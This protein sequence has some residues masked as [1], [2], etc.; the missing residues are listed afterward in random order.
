VNEL[1]FANGT[2]IAN[3]EVFQEIYTGR[4][5]DRLVQLGRVQNNFRTGAGNDIINA[6]L[7]ISDR[8]D[9]GNGEDLLI[10]NYSVEDTGT[11]VTASGSS[12]YRSISSSNSNYLDYVSFSSIERFQ[13]TG[14]SKNDSFFTNSSVNGADT[15]IGGGG[16]DTLTSY[17]GNDS[18]DGGSGNDRLTGGSGRDRFVLAQ[19][20]GTDTI[21]DFED[22]QDT[23]L[24][25]GGL[26]FGQLTITQSSNNALIG[27]AG[28]NE[29]LASLTGVQ[30]NLITEAD[31]TIV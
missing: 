28:S 22:G 10:L 11:G 8:V 12:A 31:F 16:D 2:R 29:V 19:G 15:L 13:F 9:G 24:L 26:T 20:Q 21:A 14:T 23:L 3:F 18:F 5:N 17:G 7:G 4:G 27:I 25:A 30:T 1:N 6:G